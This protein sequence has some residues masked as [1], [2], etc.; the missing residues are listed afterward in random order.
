MWD[1]RPT[2]EERAGALGVDSDRPLPASGPCLLSSSPGPYAEAVLSYVLWLTVGLFLTRVPEAYSLLRKVPCLPGV[3]S[4]CS[5]E[6][7]RV[8]KTKRRSGCPSTTIDRPGS[9]RGPWGLPGAEHGGWPQGWLGMLTQ[10]GSI[11]TVWRGARS[12]VIRV[13]LALLLTLP[14][15]SP[16]LCWHTGLGSSLHTPSL[17]CPGTRTLRTSHQNKAVLSEPPWDN[18][19]ASAERTAGLARRVFGVH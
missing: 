11:L 5:R 10:A 3:D 6:W 4:H 12:G 18:G 15:L 14:T 16:P 2:W 19:A 1:T 9:P 13:S 8:L 7:L 17:W